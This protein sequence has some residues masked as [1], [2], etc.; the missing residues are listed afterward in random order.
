MNWTKAVIAGVVGGVAVWI[1]NFIMHAVIM[2]QTYAKYPEVFSQEEGS[3]FPFLLVGVFIAVPG[4]LLF[5]KTR[6]SWG[7]G[8][9]GGAT[10]GFWLGL[11]SF[12]A[13]FYNSLVLEGFP[14][15]LA[16]C[17]GGINLIGFVILGAILGAMVKKA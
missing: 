5:A 2:G 3:P 16:W 1:A 14:Y 8:I 7:E 4:A 17:W 12:F 15:F 11:V 6:D 9:A 10:F 13:P